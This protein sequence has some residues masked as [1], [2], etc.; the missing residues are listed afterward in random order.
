MVATLVRSL[1]CLFLLPSVVPCMAQTLP[2]VVVYGKVG[3]VSVAPNGSLWLTTRTGNIYYSPS[4]DSLWQKGLQTNPGADYTGLSTCFD[5]ILF[6]TSDTAILYGNIRCA[7][8]SY[9]RNCLHRTTDGGRSWFVVRFGKDDVWVRHGQTLAGGH[10]YISASNGRIY[11]TN[12]QGLTW[13]VLPTIF[14]KERE[15]YY[16]A[17]DLYSFHFADSSTAIATNRSNHLAITTNGFATAQRIPTPLDQGLFERV[18]K[19]YYLNGKGRKYVDNWNIDK[20]RI[21]GEHLV[22]LQNRRMYHTRRDSI[23]WKAA[24]VDVLDLELDDV[25]G[26]LFAITADQGVGEFAA[27][28]NFTSWGQVNT[29]VRPLNIRVQRDVVYLLYATYLDEVGTD[30]VREHV[31]GLTVTEKNQN[32]VGGYH[33]FRATADDIRHTAVRSH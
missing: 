11:R 12:D 6:F 4:V 28:L 31:A 3:Q 18:Y 23:A 32:R 10:G 30:V 5:R 7:S 8:D 21:F 26:R 17:P 24:S 25:S 22:V 27:D 9:E 2:P 33:V 29:G 1:A 19:P 13:Q 20:V 15:A 14:G 16:R